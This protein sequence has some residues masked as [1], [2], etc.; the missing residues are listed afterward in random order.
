M[1]Q[2]NQ[3]KMQN[4]KCKMNSQRNA[5]LFHFAFCI[6]HFQL[7]LLCAGA[8]A[9]ETALQLLIKKLA[10]PD[11]EVRR[12]AVKQLRFQGAPAKE[13]VPALGRAVKDEDRKVSLDA[14]EALSRIGPDAV[15]ALIEAL[16]DQ[17][18]D[19]R[20][21]GVQ[22]LRGIKPAAK[23]AVPPLIALL[24]DA[25][26][27]V[28]AGAITALGVMGPAA[29]AAVPVLGELLAATPAAQEPALK[30]AAHPPQRAL[31]VEALGS[32][33]AKAAPILT[34]TLDHPAAEVRVLAAAALCKQGAAA[35]EAAPA[36]NRMLKDPSSEARANAA[37]ALGGIF[38][39]A[40]AKP[41]PS[42]QPSPAGGEGVKEAAENL[43]LLLKD[44]S[45]EV[46]KTA[47]AALGKIG[48]PAVPALAAALKYPDPDVR[49][50]ASD[51]LANLGVAAYPALLEAVKDTCPEVRL[52]AVEALRRPG[53]PLPAETS[54]QAVVAAL[55]E[56]LKKDES[57]AVRLRA[58]TSL[59]SFGEDAQ[60]AIPALAQALQD[61]N[62]LVRR[63]AA[64]ALGQTGVVALSSDGAAEK[65]C[66]AGLIAALEENGPRDCPG[67]IRALG[68]LG[69]SA[70][71][72]LPVL[73]RALQE[74]DLQLRLAAADAV[75]KVATAISPDLDA[76]PCL[77]PQAT[78]PPAQLKA[79][80]AAVGQLLKEAPLAAVGRGEGDCSE[81]IDALGRI[82]P[83]ASDAVPV[84]AELMKSRRNEVRRRS[85]MALSRIGAAAQ[86]AI[87]VLTV[88]LKD[89]SAEVRQYAI[90]TLSKIGAPAI[91]PLT[92]ALK[93]PSNGIRRVAAEALGKVTGIRGR[94]ETGIVSP[95]IKAAIPALVAA[96]KD[97]DFHVSEK[98]GEALA[99]V[100]LPAMP[101]LLAAFKDAEL[102]ARAPILTVIARIGPQAK[103]AI[104][105]LVEALKEDNSNYN[106]T[107]TIALA[108]DAL[109]QVGPS[110]APALIAAMKDLKGTGRIA[111]VNT[112]ARIT[113]PV[114][115]AIPVFVKMFV[116][117]RGSDS[118]ALQA[119]SKALVEYSQTA[120]EV[121]PAVAELLADP[122]TGVRSSAALLLSQMG[123]KAKDAVPALVTAT[124]D[125]EPYVRRNA[126]RALQKIGPAAAEGAP[127][128]IEQLKDP[129][130][131][132]AELVVAALAAF[133]PPAM[134][135]LTAS[136][137]L[138]SPNVRRQA[139]KILGSLFRAHEP[140]SGPLDIATASPGLRN[141]FADLKRLLKEEGWTAREGAALALGHVGAGAKECTPELSA[142]LK[143]ARPEVKLAAAWALGHI[144][145]SAKETLVPVLMAALKDERAEI[146]AQAADGL[147]QM[148][149]AAKD[150]IPALLEAIK[151]GDPES[152]AAMGQALGKIGAPALPAVT[153]ALKSPRADLRRC[154][155]WALRSHTSPAG[156]NVP[157]LAG[158]LKDNDESVRRVAA[159]AFRSLGASALVA[160]DALRA[161]LKDDDA[162]VRRLVVEVFGQLAPA[163]EAV[164]A[165]LEAAKDDSENVKLAAQDHL[166]KLGAPALPALLAA[167]KDRHP[168]VR[169][170]VMGI[171]TRLRVASPGVVTDLGTAL[172]FESWEAREGAALALGS[173]MP[174]AKE[175]VPALNKALQDGQME[176]R[177]AAAWALAHVSRENKE[178]VP[179][180][181]A[182]LKSDE[183]RIRQQAAEGL[184]YLGMAAKEAVPAL[185]QVL[186]D[187][188]KQVRNSVRR[189]LENLASGDKDLQQKITVVMNEMSALEACLLYAEA[190]DIYF[191][192]DWNNDGVLEYAQTLQ[193][194]MGLYESP[195][196]KKLVMLG[197]FQD[198]VPV[199][200]KAP[201]KEVYHFK[202]LKAQ[203]DK[204]PGGRRSYLENGHLV[205]GHALVAWPAEYGVS[206]ITTFM[207]SDSGKVYERDLG[208]ATVTLADKM[209]EFN[210]DETWKETQRANTRR[211]QKGP[212]RG[213]FDF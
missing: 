72:A 129:E 169:K 206:G 28:Q 94:S 68:K 208:A 162:E 137:R 147:A 117:E 35:Q 175:A 138:E 130:N 213:D 176:V 196:K 205:G 76:G 151:V 39:A 149:P 58:A 10:D 52:K 136:L 9:G 203:G 87:P 92:E 121:A 134:P 36:L 177:A 77:P 132:E 85:A 75:G 79:A 1:S 188:D 171:L 181:A 82:G 47:A 54:T 140:G 7:L 139:A 93:D 122:T 15:P 30:H 99:N 51:A 197:I 46:R 174:G 71:A 163:P 57:G 22:A 59:F 16:K 194:D 204:G 108:G 212:Q 157:L 11:V 24:K 187:P 119:A 144:D 89:D 198:A 12:Q 61:P 67:L 98:A 33:G 164:G 118:Y 126:L 202:I 63:K 84:L 114:K 195:A 112:L 113:P 167:L 110:A 86:A 172:S 128:L 55:G 6:L 185:T 44:D 19:V 186:R 124:K 153:E 173:F 145:P 38:G 155:V 160:T 201:V 95:E 125:E 2:I 156:E 104:P 48:V 23:D 27:L 210:P 42:P 97:V 179:I 78:I 141:V 73:T 70:T 166:R 107:R 199:R 32:L 103:E 13:A 62:Y 66:V 26:S 211:A 189:A 115:E 50:L 53:N 34:K 81:A 192:T 154:A 161:A 123:A 101:A 4:E 100:G 180:L 158:A 178:V 31:V 90:E 5:R 41:S 191:E 182:A 111:I 120:K 109:V 102:K 142:M 209:A 105:A 65:A 133:G 3:F 29:E 183:V 148:G 96:L 152:E 25:N 40:P 74:D 170:A 14:V 37:L 146:R 135:A 83:A 193:G 143:D 131:N 116:E 45:L 168:E 88:A 20:A 56:V 106:L 165:L 8:F 150:A 190:Q 17:R 69:P 21:A 43:G 91:A 60:A 184:N 159:G 64:D 49:L 80:V 200:R 18:P 207:I 127:A